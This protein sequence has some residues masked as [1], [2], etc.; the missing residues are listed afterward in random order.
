MSPERRQAALTALARG[1]RAVLLRVAVLAAIVGIAA[2]VWYFD[3]LPAVADWFVDD[4]KYHD[5]IAAAARRHGL[6]P[7]LVRALIFRESRF[8][9]RARGSRGE[10]GLMQV[11]PSGAAA[12]WARIK[13]RQRPST[14]ELFAV[15]TN[16]EIGCW[17]LARAL[18]RWRGYKECTALALAQYNAGESR[19]KA[20]AP[21]KRD[22]EVL[23]RIRIA[24]TEKYV[25]TILKRYRKYLDE[26]SGEK[27]A[28]GK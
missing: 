16:L 28:G 19:A 9:P 24:S 12:D 27:G 7:D 22:G 17:Y 18:R 25:R 14:G 13:K 15:E 2:V 20:W 11:L 4:T 23:P 3:A 21:A 1:T 5:E 10:V 26:R 8:D 6:D